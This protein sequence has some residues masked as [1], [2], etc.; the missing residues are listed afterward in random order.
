[1]I[2]ISRGIPGLTGRMGLPGVLVA[3][4]I[5]TTLLMAAA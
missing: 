3:V 1:V 5:G 4:L 2:T